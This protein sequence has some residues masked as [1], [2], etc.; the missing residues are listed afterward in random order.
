MQFTKPITTVSEVLEYLQS[1]SPHP[2]LLNPS[3][4]IIAINGTDSAALEGHFTTIKSGDVVSVVT[5]VHGG[6]PL[7]DEQAPVAIVGIRKI[8]SSE[9]GGILDDF[10]KDHNGVFIQAVR[11]ESV[12]GTEHVIRGLA[13]VKEAEKRGVMIANKAETELLL[14]FACTN[15]ISEAI[16]RV[17]LKDGSP[18]CFIA[19]S[20]RPA[21][22]RKFRDH[23]SSRFAVN[24]SVLLPSLRKKKMLASRM[25][26]DHR[27]DSNDLLNSLVECAA[28]MTK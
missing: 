20:N 8:K 3:N 28:V 16:S 22:L 9:I 24:E 14:R 17:G 6:M 2:Q 1:I 15:Q 23:V 11:A 21:E 7:L 5:V 25:G 4:L 12:Y 18:A 19:L 27:T 26:L 13:I 10:R